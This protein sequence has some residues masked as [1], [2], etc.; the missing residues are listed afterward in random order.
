MSRAAVEQYLYLLDKAFD[1]EFEHALV[2][3]ISSVRDEDWTRL[4]PSAKRSIAQ[5][6]QHV[7]D[8]KFMY[9][10]HGFGDETMD[11]GDFT[12]RWQNLAPRDAMVDWLREG[13]ATFRGCVE[14]L[15]D[16]ELTVEREA[17]WGERFETRWLI[18]AMIQ[19]DLYHAGEINHIRALLQDNDA[20]EFAGE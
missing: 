15:D 2:K 14:S 7:G 19:H 11:W 13:H 12:D 8:C 16:S 20:W 9:A 10:N 4:P 18:A 17:P 3:N 6:A 1:S 5:I